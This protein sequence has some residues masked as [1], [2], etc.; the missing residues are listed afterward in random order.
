MK[1]FLFIALAVIMLLSVLAGCS[2]A[3]TTQGGK[4][5]EGFVPAATTTAGEFGGDPV[6]DGTDTNGSAIMR[7]IVKN[8]SLD[9]EAKDVLT[10]YNEILAFVTENGGYETYRT[11]QTSDQNIIVDAQFK[12]KPEK[13]DALIEFIDIRCDIIRNDTS[14]EDI[15]TAYYDAQTR[16][17]TKELALDK[18]YEYLNDAK[19]IDESLKVQAEINSLT[20][21]IESL[22]GQIKLWDSLLAEST[23]TIRLRQLT[24]PVEQ[25]REINWS[26]LSW[27]DM[28]YLMQAGITGLLNVVVSALQWIAIVLVVSSPV[29]I[30]ALVIIWL[31]LRNSKKKRSK[32]AAEQAARQQE[33]RN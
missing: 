14:T 24:D 25:K 23:I 7:K 27:E 12:I 2:A 15:T 16:L 4:P 19:T 20:L 9:L 3:S 10:T 11:Q 32:L 31:V 30:I 13:I 6:K 22:K 8:A 18:Y 17:A 21:E 26:T 1:R 5:D 29:W 33:N 28:G